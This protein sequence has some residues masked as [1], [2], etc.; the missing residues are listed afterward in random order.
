M[1]ADSYNLYRGELGADVLVSLSDCHVS[2]LAP[3]IY[4]DQQL[5]QRYDGFIYLATVVSGGVE[6]S[7]GRRS[8]GSLRTIN[9]P[10]P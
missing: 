8:D 1:G 10:C 9:E 7:A 2:G 3:P 6:G 5:P 4:V